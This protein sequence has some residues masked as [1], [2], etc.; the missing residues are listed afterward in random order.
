MFEASQESER[1]EMSRR[2]RDR[3]KVLDGVSRK[4][5]TQKEAARLL[6][7]ARTFKRWM[8]LGRLPSSRNPRQQLPRPGLQVL[9]RPGVFGDRTSTETGFNAAP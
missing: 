4:E 7:A 6:P 5:R 9:V 1:I 2:E 3:L 8:S